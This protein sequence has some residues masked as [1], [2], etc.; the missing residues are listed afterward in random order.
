[1]A[2]TYLELQQTIFTVNHN[3]VSRLSLQGIPMCPNT[4]RA[5]QY[6]HLTDRRKVTELSLAGCQD[7]LKFQ[8]TT[9]F[10]SYLGIPM[11]VNLQTL[12]LS[13]VSLESIPDV[14]HL[15]NLVTYVLNDNN[16]SSN[17]NQFRHTNLRCLE[18]AGNPIQKVDFDVT[19][20]VK[21]LA[22]TKFIGGSILDKAA[23]SDKGL[24]IKV[25]K[26]GEKLIVPSAHIVQP[27]PW[28]ELGKSSLE[29]KVS[30]TRKI[31]SKKAQAKKVFEYIRSLKEEAYIPPDTAATPSDVAMGYH[32]IFTEVN[33]SLNMRS[34]KLTGH[35]DIPFQLVE[36]MINVPQLSTIRK[37]SINKCDVSKL[38]NLANLGQ[39]EFLDA[40]ENRIV[41]VHSSI[42]ENSKLRELYVHKN[43]MPYCDIPN[44]LK[45]LEKVTIGSKQTKYIPSHLLK[46]MA[47]GRLSIVFPDRQ[48]IY[49]LVLPSKYTFEDEC[50]IHKYLENKTEAISQIA[51]PQ[52]RQ[53]ALWHLLKNECDPGKDLSF[54]KDFA[55][56][57][58]QDG[59]Q[60][61]LCHSNMKN[62]TSLN[63][64]KCKLK[65]FPKLDQFV[66]LLHLD[67][68]E[69]DIHE[70]DDSIPLPKLNSFQI[71]QNPLQVIDIS[72]DTLP[73][74]TVLTCGSTE[75]RIIGFSILERVL[76]G[77]LK[78]EVSKEAQCCL[79]TPTYDM[80][81]SPLLL[82]QYLE[83][84]EINV[85]CT[86][87]L[88]SRKIALLW[89]AQKKKFDHLNFSDQAQFCSYLGSE[90]LQCLVTDYTNLH[91]ITAMSF[92]NCGLGKI[93]CLA[94]LS[95][96]T[97]L[98]INNNDI[99]SLDDIG[100][101]KHL[102]ELNVVETKLQGIA[103][104]KLFPNLGVL[105]VG[106]LHFK[107][108]GYDILRRISSQCLKLDVNER[109]QQVLVYPSFDKILSKGRK[110][111][112]EF[113]Q[114]CELDVSM[115]KPD[116][117]S[118]MLHWYT[119]YCSTMYQGLRLS[120]VKHSV[121]NHR[122][123]DDI[124]QLPYFKSLKFLFLDECSLID[125]PAVVQLNQLQIIVLSNNDVETTTQFQV[126]MSTKKL[127]FDGNPTKVFDLDISDHKNLTE[128]KIGSSQT[129]FIAFTTMESIQKLSVM[130]D[131]PEQY[132]DNLLMPPFET[133]RETIS[134]SNSYHTYMHNPQR[135]LETLKTEKDRE[136]ALD[137][138]FEHRPKSLTT[139]HFA[140]QVWI[141]DETVS[142]I[143]T[144]SRLDHIVMLNVSDCQ[145]KNIPDLQIMTKLTELDIRN[146]KIK[147]LI[148]DQCPLN[149]AQLFVSGNPIDTLDFN[150]G[151][152][153]Y[154]KQLEIGSKITKFISMRLLKSRNMSEITIVKEE[155]RNVLIFPS[156]DMLNRAFNQVSDIIES[157]TLETTWLEENN[158]KDKFIDWVL[159]TQQFLPSC[160]ELSTQG[161]FVAFIGSERLQYYLSH[162][163]M[164][165][166][167]ELKM[168]NCNLKTTPKLD[169]LAKLVRLEIQGNCLKELPYSKTLE[170]LDV[171]GNPIVFN[172][173]ANPCPKLKEIVIGY[174]EPM[175]LDF[176]F[177]G[178][179][180][181]NSVTI[182]VPTREYQNSI[183]MP[184]YKVLDDKDKLTQYLAHPEEF[185]E[186][187]DHGKIVKAFH[188]LANESGFTFS[189]FTADK[190]HSFLYH[191]SKLLADLLNQKSLSMVHT[192]NLNNCKLVN[193]PHVAHLQHLVTLNVNNNIIESLAKLE[194]SSLRELSI[195]EN[196]ITFIDINVNN[197][198]QMRKLTIGSYRTKY[199]CT[200]VL[201]KASETDSPFELSIEKDF[202]QNIRL[203]PYK[204]IQGGPQ[205]ITKYLENGKFD[206]T[207]FSELYGANDD[208][209]LD[210]LRYDERKIRNL[211]LSQGKDLLKR[212][213]PKG[214]SKILNHKSLQ[215]IEGLSLCKT[216]LTGYISHFQHPNVSSLD[217]S[218]SF[219]GDTVS[220][221]IFVKQ[222]PKLQTLL[223]RNCKIKCM[224][225][226]EN[227]ASLQ[228][229]DLRSNY[230][231]TFEISYEMVSLRT[232]HL[233]DNSIKSIS[234]SRA[235]IPCLEKLL[236]GS[237]Y[238]R[239]LG[240]DLLQAVVAGTLDIVVFRQYIEALL[241]P[242]CG[243][244]ENKQ[245]LE[246]YIASPDKY[247]T[248]VTDSCLKK[249]A[250]DWLLENAPNNLS[251]LDISGTEMPLDRI[252]S[253][254][255]IEKIKALETLNLSNCSLNEWPS[256]NHLSFLKR[257]NLS[258]NTKLKSKGLALVE[259]PKLEELNITH[260]PINSLS[261]HPTTS[262]SSKLRIIIGSKET[263]YITMSLL[264]RIQ[265]GKISLEVIQDFQKQLMFPPFKCFENIE[266]LAKFIEHPEKELLL[267]ENTDQTIKTLTWMLSSENS[268]LQ[269]VNLS[270]YS[271]IYDTYRD[272][273]LKEVLSS[274][275]MPTIRTLNLSGCNLKNVPDLTL[276]QNL[277]KLDLSYN[278]LKEI[279][280]K[281]NFTMMTTLVL[282]G[283]PLERI[284]LLEFGQKQ[285]S[286][287]L[288]LIECGSP[289]TKYIGLPILQRAAEG[290]LKIAVPSDHKET[291]ILP[292]YKLLHEGPAGLKKC[293]RQPE[294]YLKNVADKKNILLWS[295]NDNK[296]SVDLSGLKDICEDHN[297]LNEVL[298]S[299]KL[300]SIK[301]LNLNDC[302]LLTIPDLTHFK[303]LKSLSF[304]S[305]C[306]TTINYEMIPD[307]VTELEATGN[308]MEI[309]K[310]SYQ[311]HCKLTS[312]KVG[313][314]YLRFIP[315][316]VLER[317]FDGKLKIVLGGCTS[318][319]MPNIKVF[320]S[321]AM[322]QEYLRRP[323]YFLKDI[324]DV[325]DKEKALEWLV[326]KDNWCFNKDFTLSGQENLC[327]ILGAQTIG[328]IL[329]HPGFKTV[330]SL[331][332]D[333]CGLSEFP[334]LPNLTHLKVLNLGRNNISVITIP[335]PFQLW[336][337]EEL[338]IDEN[339][340]R[341]ID[342]HLQQ[343]FPSLKTMK[344]GS[345]VTKFLGLFFFNQCKRKSIE[346]KIDSQY[347]KFLLFPPYD[348]IKLATDKLG[349]D[350]TFLKNVL[351]LLKTVEDKHDLLHWL[352]ESNHDF[353]SFSLSHLADVRALCNNLHCSSFLS[354]PSLKNVETLFLD[355]YGLVLFPDLSHLDHLR[356]LHI[357][358]N[359][360][361]NLV[362]MT[363]LPK[364]EYIYLQGNPISD[365]GDLEAFPVLSHA[366]LGSKSTK[367]LGH[368]LLV[369]VKNGLDICIADQFESILLFPPVGILRSDSQKIS[370]LVEHPEKYL[371]H[372]QNRN[373]R[374]SAL[375]WLVEN[376]P[377]FDTLDLSNWG[378]MM[379]TFSKN[380]YS[381]FFQCSSLMSLKLLNLHQCQLGKIPII[382]HL[383]GLVE[384]NV[385]SNKIDQL[386]DEIIHATL[387]VLKL[388]GN[389][390]ANIALQ[391]FPSLRQVT[392]G[393]RVDFHV[394][395][396]VLQR[397]AVGTLTI[398]VPK[399]YQ[400]HLKLPSYRILQGG[401][402][403]IR[404]Y[405][406]HDET[407]LSNFSSLREVDLYKN[408]LEGCTKMQ[409]SLRFSFTTQLTSF[410]KDSQFQNIL[411]HSRL[412]EITS[413]FLDDCGLDTYPTDFPFYKHL[414]HVD[415]SNNKINM[416]LLS[417]SIPKSVLVLK[418]RSCCL[419]ELPDIPHLEEL[420]LNEN[421]ITTLDIACTNLRKLY[422]EKNPICDLEM[423][424]NL[425]PNLKELGAGSQELRF[426]SYDLLFRTLK[427]ELKVRIRL[428]ESPNIILP[429]SKYLTPLTSDNEIKDPISHLRQIVNQDEKKMGLRWLVKTGYSKFETLDLS[430]Q[431]C[432]IPDLESL[433]KSPSLQ[434][435]HSLDLSH[436]EL[437]AFP[438][439]V[440]NNLP[441][442]Q[443][444]D[445]SHNKLQT[446][447]PN[448]KHKTLSQ[449][450]IENNDIETLKWPLE[451]LPALTYVRCGS[452]H[453]C[454]IEKDILLKATLQ[455]TLEVVQSA[456]LALKFPPYYVIVGGK[457]AISAFLGKGG[458]LDLSSRC[459]SI[460]YREAKTLLNK[461]TVPVKC[462]ILSGQQPLCKKKDDLTKIL[463]HKNLK[464]LEKIY[465]DQ[466]NLSEIPNLKQFTELQ[467]CNLNHNKVSTPWF[468]STKFKLPC[469]RELHMMNCELESMC[470]LSALP[471]LK[472]LDISHNK[473]TS[474]E[475]FQESFA[476]PHPLEVLYIDGNP[477]KEIKIRTESFPSLTELKLGS[478][479][480][481]YISFNIL[482]RAAQKSMSIEVPSNF[483]EY[484]LVPSLK[485]LENGADGIRQ[486]LNCTTVDFSIIRSASK[487]VKALNW[488]LNEK[489]RYGGVISSLVLT[490]Q[491]D[492]CEDSHTKFSD[493]FSHPILQ[494]NLERLDLDDCGLKAVPIEKN[495]LPR[496]KYLN[497]SHNKLTD[498]TSLK[499]HALLKKLFVEGNP[500]KSVNIIGD[501][502]LKK[503]FP[504][505]KSIQAGSEY[506]TMISP[507]L[508]E[509]IVDGYLEVK[510]EK[511]YERWLYSPPH[512]VLTGGPRS[513]KA[514][515]NSFKV[516]SNS[517]EVSKCT[518]QNV[519][520]LL[521]PPETGKTSLLDTMRAGRPCTT[522]ADDRTVILEQGVLNL[523][524][525]VSIRTCDFGG[526]D[527]YELEYPI[528]LRGQNI[529]ALIVIDVEKYDE[530]QHDQ[531]VT[532]W[533][534]NCILCAD[535]NI[536][537][538]L[539]KCEN[540]SQQD[541][542]EKKRQIR[543]HIHNWKEDEIRFL[544]EVKRDMQEKAE[545][546]TETR[547]DI[548]K[549]LSKIKESLKFF[550]EDF[551][552][553]IV[554]TSAAEMRGIDELK[555]KITTMVETRQQR[556]G[557][558]WISVLNYIS[559]KKETCKYHL[560]INDIMKYL[561]KNCAKRDLAECL[562][563]FH[564]MGEFLWYEGRGEYIYNNVKNMLTLHKELF[565]HDLDTY[566]QYDLDYKSIIGTKDAFDHEKNHFLTSGFLSRNLLQCI[567]F[568][569]KL[570]QEDF[571]AMI[572]LIK[573]NNHCFDDDDPSETVVEYQREEL[574]EHKRKYLRFPWFI[575]D[576]SLDPMFWKKVW[577][578][579]PKENEIE[580]QFVCTFFM[581][582]PS[583]LYERLSVKL[584]DPTVLSEHFTR[585]DWE[586]GVYIQ[587]G[588]FKIV[589]ERIFNPGQNPML[590]VKLRGASNEP[591]TLWEYYLRI[592]HALYSLVDQSPIVTYSMKHVCPHCILTGRSLREAVRQP[593]G[594]VMR[595]RCGEQ[596]KGT[597]E[598][599]QEDDPPIAEIP[600]AFLLPLK[601]GKPVDVIS[602]LRLPILLPIHSYLT[603]S[604][605]F[606]RKPFRPKTS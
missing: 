225:I 52:A 10:M 503:E 464:D 310:A 76:A 495:Q 533:L 202:V 178:N 85:S 410:V 130:V 549:E 229:L 390:L 259:L 300:A 252:Q 6:C 30:S 279:D 342:F 284:E 489:Y 431:G 562:K 243:I 121:F 142:G 578:K 357:G 316:N 354:M 170:Q 235:F 436:C 382:S 123:L 33:P 447:P 434:R 145:L 563:Y 244:I 88:E 394:D 455:L 13:N 75:A 260:C 591:V 457:H 5:L 570:T 551:H 82:K 581:R 237:H 466:C 16:I 419:N 65:Q 413:V 344:L 383:N 58:T 463:G 399:K 605:D 288:E 278:A 491:K 456:K 437:F 544:K 471:L 318:L 517:G 335:A 87:D 346:I 188:W 569:F 575:K 201:K 265:T 22:S 395:N 524:K 305:N 101:C 451:N 515:Q 17:G 44:K 449:L 169:N 547:L 47:E 21:H 565:R 336:Q 467:Y 198:N 4:Y 212:C 324:P 155:F 313:S 403:A 172:C 134:K 441:D 554:E 584:H 113:V 330:K 482:E 406:D 504:N 103:D 53:N 18:I 299:P 333:G 251:E 400:M 98:K 546:R 133:L 56:H 264:K 272:K 386:P 217:L 440:T 120:G 233:E 347:R 34:V 257:L 168:N 520:M 582:F 94:H 603:A 435:I 508:L 586:N 128:L 350:E 256:V 177:L 189:S 150:P 226:T 89:L 538:V 254:L 249:E 540:L 319:L 365:Y 497:V 343:A 109:Y 511:G 19:N 46:N 558:T 302:G 163:T 378:Y 194:S 309:L 124:L 308:P 314:D 12:D 303:E 315:S 23:K 345:R 362:S 598:N 271:A 368:N 93:P 70:I 263:R 577:P 385:T 529:I 412:K 405:L 423:K 156:W 398:D 541:L 516:N 568:K 184:P 355:H 162:D 49:Y 24:D 513:I 197:C 108:L 166:I 535:C 452:G 448:F 450:C 474:C 433:M 321:R 280:R 593:L 460:T 481:T 312:I 559:E 510:I 426:V 161:D 174:S 122:G 530:N 502:K 589:V 496:L 126:P 525:N 78:L 340:I 397:A 66:N 585:K 73:S 187:V 531:L 7:F 220:L 209:I 9:G 173:S 341:T 445:L 469:L 213:G 146:N 8:T 506:T 485:D 473:I 132:R 138:L 453:M 183:M 181:G 521:G 337:L 64:S 356:V 498:L 381:K 102:G 432:L 55:D 465:V 421:A 587:I 595:G 295:F 443:V 45:K 428:D 112:T 223:L 125:V 136:D 391:S 326:Y 275:Q 31:M 26:H 548:T 165:E 110:T 301:H 588:D 338:Y 267:F 277:E 367:F 90:M 446:I 96:L 221:G 116:E 580:F 186:D 409:K 427:E 20:N 127:H 97:V 332:L 239:Y 211:S 247:L 164:K 37:L 542:E 552:I 42:S 230:L 77:S 560:H 304:C 15:Q 204:I 289:E 468:F 523:E 561:G 153:P 364:L 476:E 160:F 141:T 104:L 567:W 415:L 499:S 262:K 526:H 363:E 208:M 293:V 408:Q 369:K 411:K 429:P 191:D 3:K 392:F 297:V 234:L 111:I 236:V 67:I 472:Y 298:R 311:T 583:T 375:I 444:L 404:G 60:N 119:T 470:N 536:I 2:D 359:K 129:R 352:L 215:S 231:H 117:A 57:V 91:N 294:S 214:I 269:S 537:F 195:V 522:E 238:T 232:L 557:D 454:Y 179:M 281:L 290:K 564:R 373:D 63:M 68:A 307:S 35:R 139:L 41:T 185:L 439:Q 490:D 384:L 349:T 380:E 358:F 137:W 461:T 438:L 401:S 518:A 40:S 32:H 573:I 492:F 95:K 175:C 494:Q 602:R 590:T 118:L 291:L 140:G 114:K 207:V 255:L 545:K 566:L 416:K 592:Y 105:T 282:T 509:A 171:S 360:I 131:V 514:W 483:K 572:Q 80:I 379:N 159:S 253:I 148:L 200:S 38:P 286:P 571:E 292:P 287:N 107:Y 69:N 462:F 106:S 500:I 475:K 553:E 600:M 167:S 361:T 28:K 216:D 84:R 29:N 11:F 353:S 39:L 574:S 193:V 479:E 14:A 339:P 418:L 250:L 539:S 206:I 372:I 154:L 240:F 366:T 370:S 377:D 241:L 1:M 334:N 143:L 83:N 393:S 376:W 417:K 180:V 486:F 203:P 72:M 59:L 594:A 242:P 283:N 351:E 407:D 532:R 320:N 228:H 210:A 246:T 62:V 276:L 144:R 157:S 527:I 488:Y 458:E 158:T 396:K 71:Q 576:R 92:E 50:R 601:S 505:L 196:P 556:L 190:M 550:K 192:L 493:L 604:F 258:R 317:F 420:D 51:D 477:I 48:D 389:P 285:T 478:E 147:S 331:E 74:L 273:W 182:K 115:V 323:E 480:T 599:A 222:F 512:R 387:Q 596:L 306:V 402:E 425:F 152:V 597:C 79:L 270:E 54:S 268:T 430:G 99:A 543:L 329:H 149:L 199:I 261:I 219:I 534:E 205:S 135:Y 424:R 487:R 459:G 61:I 348:Y 442:L 176:S 322:L 501:G 579:C 519:L 388:E 422:I 36:M 606:Y 274:P 224:R 218:G 484:L 371:Q 100:I 296:Q 328:N 25:S 248:K 266:E 245:L 528:F 325:K 374:K 414:R 227:N 86:E 81:N 151:S 27:L 327:S 43:P 507:K 555:R